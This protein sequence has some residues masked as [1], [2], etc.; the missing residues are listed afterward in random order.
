MYMY[1]Y[2]RAHTHTHTHTHKYIYIYIYIYIYM[3]V[4]I[5]IHIIK[6]AIYIYVF[7]G[8]QWCDC[9]GIRGEELQTC[10]L[11]LESQLLIENVRV[12]PG[13]ISRKFVIWN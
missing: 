11:R 9:G 6:F 7:L 4:Y 12:L 1:M 5:Y 2:T 3:C 10:G 8:A 13:D